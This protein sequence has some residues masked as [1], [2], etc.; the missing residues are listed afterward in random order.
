M[1]SNGQIYGE[2]S[3]LKLSLWMTKC[4]S[5]VRSWKLKNFSFDTKL[6]RNNQQTI[7]LPSP[8]LQDLALILQNGFYLSVNI[9]KHFV[10]K[11]NLNQILIKVC[12]L[13]LILK[14]QLIG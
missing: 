10:S 2:C 12:E 6:Q 1:I 8:V 5:E 14:G 3:Q 9:A 4:K 11:I 7:A 13:F